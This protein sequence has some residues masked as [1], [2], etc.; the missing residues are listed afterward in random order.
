MALKSVVCFRSAI[1][2]EGR[3]YTCYPEYVVA[4][5]NSALR[6]WPPLPPS[7][8][9]PQGLVIAKEVF[10]AGGVGWGSADFDEGVAVVVHLAEQAKEFAIGVGA[11]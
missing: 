10:A 9:V 4:S 7:Q 11:G 6:K 1:L 3:W 8:F 5:G 2:S